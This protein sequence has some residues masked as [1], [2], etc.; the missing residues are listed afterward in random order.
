ML[1]VKGLLRGGIPFIVMGGIALLL[2]FQGKYSDAK[3]TFLTGLIIFFVSAASVIYNI[4]KWSLTKQSGFH[5][6]LMLI[7]IYPLL[8]VSGW[9]TVTS[10]FDA[11][12]VFIS[13][14]LVGLLLWLVFFMLAKYFSW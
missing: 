12:I 5:F 6:I 11:F 13:F 10:V 3:S 1:V 4:D 14:L 7:T 9:Y 8:L 2:Y